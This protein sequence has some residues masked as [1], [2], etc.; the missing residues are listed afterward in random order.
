MDND[1]SMFY[2]AVFATFAILVTGSNG[3]LTRSSPNEPKPCCLPK[4][5]S[6]QMSIS[7]GM[8]LPDGKPYSSHDEAILYFT[9]SSDGLCIPLSG[10][11]YSQ[12]PATVNSTTVTNFVPKIIDPDAFDIPEECKN[13]A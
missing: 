8:I 4:Q 10:H 1:F 6:S 5:H 11:S 3:K 12:N 13:A 9:V 7:T 2:Y